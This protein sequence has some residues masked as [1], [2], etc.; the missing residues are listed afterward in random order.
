VGVGSA[1]RFLTYLVGLGKTYQATIRLGQAT[2]TDDSDG[3]VVSQAVAADLS[4]AKVEQAM[5]DLRGVIMQVPS[6]VSAIKVNG[7]R[8]YARVRSGQAVTLAARRVEISQFEVL[9]RRIVG[10]WLDLDVVV[11]CGT[12]TYVRALARDLGQ[13]LA[14][15]GHLTALRRTRVGPFEVTAART[16]DQLEKRFESASLAETATQLMPSR[17]LTADEVEHLRCGRTIAG[18]AA[19]VVSVEPVSPGQSVAG[20]A[21][22]VVSVEPV[23]PGR[24]SD[25]GPSGA[26][27]GL[28]AGIAPDGSLVALIRDEPGLDKA[29][30]VAVFI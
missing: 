3:Q 16:L 24:P 27:S 1:T 12:G 15:G 29:R 17:S 8:A 10:D 30:P 25:S 2:T 23:S 19:G 9:A 18:A 14:V 4:P 7:Q 11:E 20:A 26:L 21:A 6:S 5:A 22:G 13:T 28:V